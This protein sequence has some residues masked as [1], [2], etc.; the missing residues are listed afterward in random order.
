MFGTRNFT[1]QSQILHR[2]TAVRHST[3]PDG[4]ELPEEGDNE[5]GNEEEGK[6]EEADE[7]AEDY[8]DENEEK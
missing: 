1:I 3:Y 6:D 2:R 5:E 4:E 7:D 8:E